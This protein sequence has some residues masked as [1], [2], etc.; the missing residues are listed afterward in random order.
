MLL[1]ILI[2]KKL[3]LLS[4]VTSNTFLIE[5]FIIF[6]FKKIFLKICFEHCDCVVVFCTFCDYI[7]FVICHII[8]NQ[9]L[10]NKI[11]DIFQILFI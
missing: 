3:F 2:D 1:F 11:V 8:D 7:K 6:I 4:Y 5:S 9:H 10:F